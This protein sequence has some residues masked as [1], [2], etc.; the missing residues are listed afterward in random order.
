MVVA[1][2]PILAFGVLLAAVTVPFVSLGPGPIFNTLGDFDGKPVVQIE[3][4]ETEPTSGQL[5][6]TTVSQR[7]ALTL[8]QALTLWL[9]G[10]EQLLP[11]DLVYPPEKTRDDI[12]KANQAEFKNSEDSAAFAALG[13]LDYPKA[14]TVETVSD[15]GPAK[16]KLQP[17]D[18]IDGVNGTPVATVEAFTSL[19][20]HTKPGD[21][22]V[23]DYRRKNEAPGTTNITLGANDDRDYGFLGV[24]VRDAP[25]A[26]FTVD[27]NLANIGGPSAGLIFSLAVIDKLTPANS[28]T[29][30][31]SPAPAPSPGMARSAA[32][33]ASRTSWPLPTTP[34]PRCSWCPPTTARRRVRQNTTACSW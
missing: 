30:A 20:E 32:S 5:N 29:A 1:L 31:S 25:W 21:V 28:T 11:R 15:D 8:G 17:G 23:V 22:I 24:G 12:D 9:S 3:G 33:A 13:F 6:M 14:V 34:V 16:D 19:L 7:D 18:A 2:V 27:F 4:T 10:R 26:P